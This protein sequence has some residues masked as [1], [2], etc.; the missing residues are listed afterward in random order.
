MENEND[1]GQSEMYKALSKLNGAQVKKPVGAT[2][3]GESPPA[4]SKSPLPTLFINVVDTIS[5]TILSRVSHSHASEPGS[6]R[7]DNEHHIPVVVTENWVVYSFVNAKSRRTEIGVMTLHE[8]MIDKYGIS[9]FSS[10]EQRQTFSSL[11]DQK[12]IVLT[13]TFTVNYPISALGVTNTKGGISSKTILVATG[14]DGKILKIDRRHL[15]PRRPFGE[16]KKTEKEEGL[17]QYAPLLPM[18]PM[19]VESYSNVVENASLIISTA[20][21]LES[22]TCILAVGGPDVFFTRFAP[23]RE[24][25]SLPENFNKLLIVIVVVGLFVVMNVIKKMG[26][27]KNIKLFW[28]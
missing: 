10:P 27:K 7:D 23:S 19:Q 11:M 18:V 4:K 21:N 2:K 22:Q 9:A 15:D 20:T 16:P 3:P 26:D 28:S 12:P 17:M 8:G 25:D 5:G 13:K 6:A 24:F 1:A 14:V